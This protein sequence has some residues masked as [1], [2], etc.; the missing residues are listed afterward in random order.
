[1]VDFPDLLQNALRSNAP[2]T[3][4]DAVVHDHPIFLKLRLTISAC[5]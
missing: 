2:M 5:A 1:M 3:D 4:L